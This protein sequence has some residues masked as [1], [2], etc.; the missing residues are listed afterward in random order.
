M[1]MCIHIVISRWDPIAGETRGNL[2]LL[3]GGLQDLFLF[4]H[5]GA[6]HF[7]ASAARPL[8]GEGVPL[9]HVVYERTP[10]THADLPL[11]SKE[12]S[13]PFSCPALTLHTGPAWVRL[14]L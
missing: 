6:A 10:T 5:R 8:K 12:G 7:C 3:Y 2:G 9:E 13:R 4:D 14:V 1:T 11:V